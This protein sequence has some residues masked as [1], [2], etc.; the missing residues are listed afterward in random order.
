MDGQVLLR[1][2]EA[3]G[4]ELFL[5]L[6][7][8]C[9][10]RETAEDLMQE[11]FVKALLSLPDGHANVR[12]WLYMVARNL[13]YDMCRKRKREVPWEGA[14]PGDAPGGGSSG[15]EPHTR[16]NLSA[17]GRRSGHASRA[18]GALDAMP[19][20]DDVLDGLIQKEE[21]Q[22]LYM[23]LSKLSPVKRVILELQY[24]SGLPLRQVAAIVGVRQENVRVLSHRAKQEVKKIMKEAG[25]EVS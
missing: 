10:S 17:G 1:L 14:E 7:S 16:G 13:Y 11:T 2:Y 5:Y 8:L 20:S 19:G 24:F 25:Y 18:C 15:K 23:T 9:K 22:M 12:A 3:Y 6:Y 4:R 21:E